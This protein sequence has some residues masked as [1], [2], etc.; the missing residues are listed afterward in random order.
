VIFDYEKSNSDLAANI[1]EP[2]L[3]S[4]QFN[5]RLHT[6]EIFAA[7][8]ILA[9]NPP[10][11][12]PNVKDIRS[13]SLAQA[14]SDLIGAANK[15]FHEDLSL[16]DILEKSAKQ[17][18]LDLE[19]SLKMFEAYSEKAANVLV[20]S[21]DNFEWMKELEQTLGPMAGQGLYL[22]DNQGTIV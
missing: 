4:L 12:T 6:P 7:R 2:N 3:Y 19:N 21:L 5:M 14:L 13:L 9:L 1:Q 22:L 10:A 18:V 17:L 15:S 20:G 16:D 11:V 8:G